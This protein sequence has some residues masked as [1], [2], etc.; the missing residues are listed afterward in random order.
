MNWLPLKRVLIRR[1]M[2]WVCERSSAAS[3]SSRIYMGAGEYCRRARISERAIRD[4]L[5]GGLEERRKT[6]LRGP[7]AY[8]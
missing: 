4:L 6:D 1:P 2:F 5:G 3:T 8:L 7:K